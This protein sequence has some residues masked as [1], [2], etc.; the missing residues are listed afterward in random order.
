MNR[1]Q[2]TTYVLVMRWR[3]ICFS[4]G[5]EISN[6]SYGPPVSQLILRSLLFIGQR[7][8]PQ[9]EPRCR[10]STCAHGK[11][12][13]PLPCWK[14][15]VKVKTNANS[16]FMT[17]SKKNAP[18]AQRSDRSETVESAPCHFSGENKVTPSFCCL[19]KVGRRFSR[20]LMSTWAND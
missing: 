13:W 3:Y 18:L 20:S 8:Q 1:P 19:T 4:N 10:K 11:A 2:Q 15:S 5:E 14:I 16:L 6:T 9:N 7:L 12:R 17:N